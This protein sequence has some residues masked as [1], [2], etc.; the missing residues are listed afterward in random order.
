MLLVLAA[1]ACGQLVRTEF[2]ETKTVVVKVDTYRAYLV[3]KVEPI[4]S[5]ALVVPYDGKLGTELPNGD[6]RVDVSRLELVG[7]FKRLDNPIKCQQIFSEALREFSKIKVPAKSKNKNDRRL[8]PEALK[9]AEQHQQKA[10]HAVADKYKITLEQLND[11]V[12]VG[13]AN[14]WPNWDE[15]KKTDTKKAK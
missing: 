13:K 1:L 9:K 15:G 11:I 2:I 7:E 3:I 10:M 4:T 8:Y 12:E 6:V 14:A 5:T